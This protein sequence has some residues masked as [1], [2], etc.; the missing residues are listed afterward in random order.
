MKAHNDDTV[1]VRHCWFVGFGVGL[2]GQTTFLGGGREE[3][4]FQRLHD[5]IVPYIAEN[6]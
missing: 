4:E 3:K 2:V 5:A 1:D 6:L